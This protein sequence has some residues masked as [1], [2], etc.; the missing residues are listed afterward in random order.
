MKQ[1]CDKHAEQLSEQRKQQ[2]TCECGSVCRINEKARHE[3][4]L[5]HQNF[6]QNKK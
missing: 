5:K 4:T 2:F 6:I 1:Y 3:R